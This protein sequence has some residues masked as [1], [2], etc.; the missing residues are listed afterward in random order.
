MSDNWIYHT[1]VFESDNFNYELMFFSPWAGHRLFGYD[2]ICNE[3]PEVIVELGSHYGCS[4]F[5]FLQGIKDAKLNS[6][7][8]AVDTWE[9]DSYTKNDYAEDIYAEYRKIQDSCFNGQNAKML[10]MKFE[11]AVEEFEDESID[12]LHIDGSHIYEDVK[13]DFLTWKSKVKKEGVIFFHDISEDVVLGE[14]MG[15]Y[16]FWNEIKHQFP[17]CLE[18]PHSYGLGVLFGGR[19]KWEKIVQGVEVDYYVKKDLLSCNEYKNRLRENFFTLKD[20]RRHID[21]LYERIEVQQEHLERYEKSVADKERCISQMEEELQATIQ[22]IEREYRETI[23]GKEKYIE[24]LKQQK[25]ACEHDMNNV[26]EKYSETILGKEKYIKE[27]QGTVEKYK[28]SVSEKDNYILQLSNVQKNYEEQVKGKDVYIEELQNTI[29]RYD[30]T[31]KGKDVY[32]EELQNIIKRYD[33][34]VRGKDVYIE[35]LLDVITKYET[36][37]RGKEQYIGE[38]TKIKEDLDKYIMD[39]NDELQKQKEEVYKREKYIN[40]LKRYIKMSLLG[41]VLLWREEKKTLK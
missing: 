4:A 9:G 21:S 15:S 39:L 28:L 41:R 6:I 11:E 36:T 22:K 10:R 2:Y 18:F 24:E 16:H 33:S 26:A 13:S 5:T 37:V 3:K 20:D 40:V 23:D 25:I 12:L 7:F 29:K 1:P 35:E 27:L 34:T 30:S 8:Y 38:L 19:E 17:F 14:N 31:V 32:I